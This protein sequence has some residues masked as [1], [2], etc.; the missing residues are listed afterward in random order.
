MVSKLFATTVTYP[1]QTMKSRVQQGL[2]SDG[3]RRYGGLI[4]CAVQTWRSEGPLAFYR[5]FG[6]SIVR[7]LPASMLT[8]TLYEQTKRLLSDPA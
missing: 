2:Q 7:T 4:D 3:T 5:G 6:T 8:L 1:M